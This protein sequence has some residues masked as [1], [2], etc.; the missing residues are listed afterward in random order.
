LSSL[1]PIRDVITELEAVEFEEL[2]SGSAIARSAVLGPGTFL[3]RGA[4]IYPGVSIGTR[5]IV[6]DGAVIGRMPIPTATT[7][8]PVQATFGTV[9]IGDDTVVGA[10]VVLY[11][12][13][14]FGRNVLVGDLTSVREGCEI[15][16]GAILGRSVMALYDCRIGAFSRIQDQVHLVGDMIVEEH[17][18]I[19][20]GTVTTNDNDVYLARFGHRGSDE[21]QHGPTIRR[22]AMIGAGSTILPNL[23]IGTGAFVAAGAVVTR[24]VPPW[25]I[26]AGVPAR[27]VRAVPDD[28]RRTIEEAAAAREA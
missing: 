24:D 11:T 19:G 10:N 16:D 23:E 25:T 12:N 27:E 21:P 2:P 8:R 1:V 20:M 17:V 6:L 26:F 18:F 28:W 22:L 14:R 7:T 15:S 4:T 3:G 13:T 9:T 5:C